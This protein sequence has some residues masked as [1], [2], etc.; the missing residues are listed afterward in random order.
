VVIASIFLMIKYLIDV[1]GT[2]SGIERFKTVVYGYKYFLDYP[3]LGLGWGVFPTY[4]FLINLLVNFG[5][6]GAIPFTILIYNIVI[7]FKNKIKFS[8][9][10]DNY[11]YRAGIESFVLLI[12]VSQLSGFIY[13]SQYFWLYLGIA[14]SIGSLELKKE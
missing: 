8:S 7:K 12:I 3:I 2:Y 1:S 5:I 14:I 4:D 10:K 9:K 11:L 13:H 6:M